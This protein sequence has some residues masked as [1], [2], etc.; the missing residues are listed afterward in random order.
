LRKLGIGFGLAILLL[1]LFVVADVGPPVHLLVKER[2][3]GRY[4]VQ[5]RVPKVLPARAVPNP[6]L[7]EGC[8]PIGSREVIDQR[9]AWLLT[10]E[11]RCSETIAGQPLGMN[12]P[13]RDLTLTTVMKV[14][15]ASG[16][17]FAHLLMQG[18]ESW[19][20]PEGTGTP[21]FIGNA[22]RAV[23]GGASHVVDS[24]IHLVFLGVVA[25]FGASKLRP[26][27]ELVSAFTA[28]QLGGVVLA[29]ATPLALGAA[30]AEMALA[31]V[32]V[33]L[34]REALLASTDQ[35]RL[36]LLVA[37]G[38]GA[39]GL[40]LSGI[41]AGSLAGS[42]QSLTMQLVAVVGMDATHLVGVIGLAVVG[43]RLWRHNIGPRG[44]RLSAY[45]GGALS[46]AMA[47]GLA[48]G[49]GTEEMRAS[50]SSALLQL[51][52][53]GPS[54]SAASSA[55]R[56]VATAS[57]NSVVQSFLSIEP[58]EVR[59]EV[60]FRLAGLTEELSLEA[61][62][63]IES[64]SQAAVTERLA[65]FA[66]ASTLVVVD[67]L[68]LEP[69]LRRADFMA[70]DPTGALPRTSPVPEPVAEAAVGVILAY[71]TAG[72][73]EAVSLT[74]ETFPAEVSG[75]PAT[76]IDP[77]SVA[78]LSLTTESPSL[79]WENTLVEDPVPEITAVPV[80]P[81]RLPLP[82]LSL[83]LIIATVAL[84]MMGL[85]GVRR[86][87]MF[88]GARLTLALSF[89]V[90]PLVE[91]AVAVPG[92]YGRRPSERQARRIL[93]G[94]LPNIYRAMGMR[95]EAMIYDRLAVTVTGETLTDVYL[96]QRRALAVEERGGAQARVE[97]VEVLEANE[98]ESLASG[99]RVRAG[100]TVGGMVTHFGHRHFR[101]NRYDANIGIVPVDGT[102][103]LQSIQVLEQERIQ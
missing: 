49:S 39:H 47:F 20:L 37:V 101:Q 53:A 98:I 26:P 92:T 71:R 82:I 57:P 81:V 5:W 94:V 35:R 12:Y 38:G 102:W 61:E 78:T 11:W 68:V 56:R 75:I 55:S 42:T 19:Q 50:G 10:Q 16:D 45:A 77:E 32:T 31:V 46:M 23:Q 74:W 73:A 3:P 90:G 7:P 93:S 8:E 95:D 97:A 52:T 13:F 36:L 96:Q 21:D 34:A 86:E 103:K 69:E 100:W 33:L 80:E 79:T 48:L 30:F 28:G 89:L 9:D 15:L 63:T 43:G 88:T 51:Q 14:E 67:G 54:S 29:A 6:V 41:L 83:P 17:R 40:A 60:M 66:R 24:W 64:E 84:A 72:M 91:T 4:D 44:R 65:E 70:V 85:R 18:E 27:I 2:Q 62:A 1:P 25:R 58:F 76:V 59:H 87:W 99:F 22:R